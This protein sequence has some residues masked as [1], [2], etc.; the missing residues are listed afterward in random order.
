[1]HVNPLR[2][3]A[4]VQPSRPTLFGF[5]IPFSICIGQAPSAKVVYAS[6]LRSLG[7]CRTYAFSGQG[8]NSIPENSQI[9][10]SRKLKGNL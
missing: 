3:A 4:V 6:Y 10:S 1:M 8:V 2:A 7:R 9:L 5:A